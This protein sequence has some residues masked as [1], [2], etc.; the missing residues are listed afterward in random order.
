MSLDVA[1]NTT[2][3]ENLFYNFPAILHVEDSYLSLVSTNTADGIFH[4]LIIKVDLWEGIHYIAR[5]F[6][7]DAF[8]GFYQ[9]TANEKIK[10]QIEW[11]ELSPYSVYTGCLHTAGN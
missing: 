7:Y 11:E 6:E 8:T 5:Y 3:E 1:M 4:C 9:S 10:I 2:L